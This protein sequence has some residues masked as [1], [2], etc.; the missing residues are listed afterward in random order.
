MCELADRLEKA[1]SGI[2]FDVMRSMG[3]ADCILP[4]SL[5]P[6]LPQK[7]IAG[8]IFTVN[9]REA[10]EASEQE[11]L[12]EWCKMLSQAPS[13]TVILCQPNNDAV[14]HMGELSAE[15][16]Q[17]K[18]V[19]G[20]IVDGG[21]RDSGFIESVGFP[22]WCRYY[23]PVDIV[24]RWVPDEFNAPIEIG[25]VTIRANDYVFADRD[26]IAII[27]QEIAAEVAKRAEKMMCT[28][29]L[30]RKAILEGVDPVEAYLKYGKF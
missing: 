21:C 26:G 3:H 13:D 25:G 16:L 11:T 14:S 24:S 6:L 2:I 1:Y 28:E 27:P 9:G 12:L 19:R 4:R 30:V 20:Y 29:N 7:R 10:P 17:Y 8:R 15:T 22:V 23:T 18:G 5:R